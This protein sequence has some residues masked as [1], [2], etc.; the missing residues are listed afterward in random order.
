MFILVLK[1]SV[2][3]KLL[4]YFSIQINY[5]FIYLDREN[6][7]YFETGERKQ[8]ALIPGTYQVDK[9]VDFMSLSKKCR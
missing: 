6:L 4:K 7:P 1:L 2:L 3:L 8:S 9:I 5:L